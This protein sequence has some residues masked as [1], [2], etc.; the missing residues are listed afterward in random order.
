[1]VRMRR[2]LLCATASHP[3]AHRGGKHRDPCKK[4]QTQI[5]P[6]H[7]YHPS[8]PCGFKTQRLIWSDCPNKTHPPERP[9]AHEWTFRSA[10]GYYRRG[11]GFAD[12]I[13]A[14]WA[15]ADWIFADRRGRNNRLGAWEVG[16]NCC[17]DEGES[18]NTEDHEFQHRSLR[19]ESR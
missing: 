18:C 7:S 15:L 9:K 14:D 2:E 16:S 1:M 8:N 19:C 13:F 11:R 12:R 6:N 4:L 10:L 17:S 5:F 3:H